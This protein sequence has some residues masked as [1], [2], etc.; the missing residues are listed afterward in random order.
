IVTLGLVS[1]ARLF[2]AEPAAQAYLGGAFR[3]GALIGVYIAGMA[4]TQF[5]GYLVWWVALLALAFI[6]L[7]EFTIRQFNRS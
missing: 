5:L 2:L 4:L 7:T 1:L 6:L 3:Q